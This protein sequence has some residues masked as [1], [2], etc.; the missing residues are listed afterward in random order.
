[1]TILSFLLNNE[2]NKKIL[3]VEKILKQ[4]GL[5]FDTCTEVS[6]GCITRHWYLD[7]SLKGPLLIDD[8]EAILDRIENMKRLKFEE[9]TPIDELVKRTKIIKEK[10]GG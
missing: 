6:H 9:Q 5:E 3:E 2:E 7:A 1:M 4:I 8:E 10:H